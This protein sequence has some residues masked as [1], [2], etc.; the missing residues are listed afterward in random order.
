MSISYSHHSTVEIAPERLIGRPA[1][2]FYRLGIS[3]RFRIY[4]NQRGPNQPLHPA[5]LVRDLIAE[6]Y[7]RNSKQPDYFLGVAYPESPLIFKLNPNDQETWC[8]FYLD[9]D[10]ARLEALEK[11]R[12]GGD[13]WF[14]SRWFCVV[15]GASGPQ[16]SDHSGP[17]LHANQSTWLTVLRE[18]NYRPSLLFE[19][20][21]PNDSQHP[22]LR[23]AIRYLK[24]A[25]EDFR[26]GHN[27]DA[28]GDCRKALEA[29]ATAIIEPD[30]LR[31]AKQ[32][33]SKTKGVDADA[34]SGSREDM[35]VNHRFLM[36]YETLRHVANL[37][38]HAAPSG[39][40]YKFAR[41][42][43]AAVIASTAVLIARFCDG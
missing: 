8:L 41:R 13:L 26:I 21:I 39:E 25:E 17:E 22:S 33:Y 12:D 30:Q 4:G 36:V 20:P 35:T 42:D 10:R 1:L 34:E 23:E 29:C 31:K 38:P 28:I 40:E 14:R 16:K 19:I 7:V 2:G 6:I 32:L 3:T 5:T 43:A 27:N 37:A 11:L 9:L 24:A 15:D 18:M